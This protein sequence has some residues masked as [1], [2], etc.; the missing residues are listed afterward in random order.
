MHYSGL[1]IDEPPP[2]GFRLSCR[3]RRSFV[4]RWWYRRQGSR[5]GAVYLIS[6]PK[7]GRTWVRLM[8][9][10]AL[11]EHFGLDASFADQMALDHL[12]ERWPH[13][14]LIIPRHDD[15]PQLKTPSELVDCKD[16]YRNNLVILLVRDL[17]DLAVSAYFQMSRRRGKFDGS[18]AEFLHS[19]RGGFATMLRF[20]NIWAAEKDRPKG[21]LLVRY[22]D[23]HQDSCRE[24][25]RM[26]DFIGLRQIP[27]EVLA[28]AAEYASFENM[29]RLETQTSGPQNRLDGGTAS[30]PE[31]LKTR[32]GKVGR[33]AEYMSPEDAVWTTDLMV[34]E[35]D[36]M[37]GYPYEPGKPAPG[38]L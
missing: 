9:G 6:F 14:P 5:S 32:K 1:R 10:H 18:L 12:H 7:A 29:R 2:L 31:S 37:Y 36:P 19:P 16:E 17:R 21:F 25:R 15:Y 33:F 20:H 13:V 28:S 11:T 8:L 24:L 4:G 23:L 3:L 27:D 26:L 38:V 35:L 34:R 30:D 22:E